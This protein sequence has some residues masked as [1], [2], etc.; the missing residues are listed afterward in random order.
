[1][2]QLLNQTE[3]LNL[4]NY[5]DTHEYLPKQEKNQNIYQ[6]FKAWAEQMYSAN[7][8][9]AYLK[10]IQ[11]Y[12]E[13]IEFED[14]LILNATEE[15]VNRFIAY[16]QDLKNSKGKPKFKKTTLNRQR[17][18]VVALYQYLM[19]MKL[20]QHNVAQQTH[21][22]KSSRKEDNA[23]DY[24]NESETQALLNQIRYFSK[25]HPFLKT[26]DHFLV[27][28]VINTGLRINELIR[29]ELSQ[30]DFENHQLIIIDH[31]NQTRVV[32]LHEGL[33][34]DFL[35]YL[36]Q[37]NKLTAI[38]NPELVFVTKNGTPMTTQL[39]NSMLYKHSERCALPKRANNSILRHTYA[40]HLIEAGIEVEEMAI[41]LGHTTHY[42]TLDVYDKFFKEKET[43][44]NR[45][46]A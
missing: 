4:I 44:L 39:T 36:E 31:E 32:P 33:K 35:L 7:S 22:I 20:L 26:R 23:V 16:N 24:L 46:F 45:L 40:H 21:I 9:T 19:D 29:L 14:E 12:I 10:D 1:M 8:V 27:R 43:G 3:E 38:E 30:L 42:F 11:R 18:S 5:R 25:D 41:L 34:A 6:A 13:F 17:A 2:N 28:L 15:T 37:R